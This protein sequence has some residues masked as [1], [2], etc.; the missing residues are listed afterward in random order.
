M[1][2]TLFERDHAKVSI[3]SRG[4]HFVKHARDSVASYRRAMVPVQMDLDYDEAALRAGKSPYIDLDI[5]AVLN[6]IELPSF[7]ELRLECGTEYSCES[8]HSLIQK[9]ID[10]ALVISPPKIGSITFVSLRR[11]PFQIWRFQTFWKASIEILP[12]CSRRVHCWA[13]VP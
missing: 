9:N 13:M 8:V 3:T 12:G 5:I 7:P 11:S 10:I 1:R 4:R 2:A 6:A